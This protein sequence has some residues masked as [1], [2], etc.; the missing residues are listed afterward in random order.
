MSISFNIYVMSY[1]RA[2]ITIS[3][4]NFNDCTYVVREF[5]A[6]EYR[7]AGITNLLVIP[8]GATLKNGASVNGFMS[9]FFWILENTPEEVVCIVDDDIKSYHFR[10][11]QGD[12]DIMKNYANHKD[13]VENEIERLAQCLVDLD[14]G[15]L[16][17]HPTLNPHSFVSEFE[18]VG[19]PGSTRIVNKKAFK[20][21]FNPSDPA[22]SDVDMILQELLKNRIV[23]RTSYF[24]TGTLPNL[25]TQGGTSNSKK[26]QS[27]L[28]LAIKNKWGRYFHYDE[29]HSFSRIKVK[30]W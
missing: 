24:L 10:C 13:I 22:T 11:K 23:L 15:M 14:L 20:A 19:A 12:I 25:V 2:K 28:H 3:H 4:R 27:D 8:N 5:E 26:I 18:F 16:C 17:T 7:D 9:T 21:M 29:E 6:D 1:K 30:R